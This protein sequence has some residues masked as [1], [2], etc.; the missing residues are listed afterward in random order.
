[1]L[2]GLIVKGELPRLFKRI[3]VYRGSRVMK[4]GEG[5]LVLP[6]A[7]FCGMLEEGTLIA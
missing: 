7:E 5:I 3:L 1:M 4:T 2:K 6:F